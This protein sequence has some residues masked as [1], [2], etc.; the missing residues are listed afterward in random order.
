[1]PPSHNRIEISGLLQQRFIHHGQTTIEGNIAMSLYVGLDIG[2]TKFLVAS[3]DRD[4]TILKRAQEST[5]SDLQEGIDLL[6]EMIVSVTDGEKPAAIGAAIGGPL[7]WKRGVVSPLHQPQWR[8]V[9]LKAMMADRWGCPFFVDVD[10]N[11]A[12]L[13]EYY[14]G[15]EKAPRLLYLT[16]STGMGGSLLVDGE[17][18]RGAGGGH[19]EVAH[20]SINYHCRRP[21]EIECECGIPDCLEA[22]VSGNG[23]RRVYRRPAEC[24]TEREWDEVAYN[25]GQGLRNLAAIYL[26][27]VIVLGGGVALGRGD[28]LVDAASKVMSAHLRIVPVPE[29]RLSWLGYETALLG[30]IAAAIHGIR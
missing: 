27:D 8:E 25:L 24:L 5:P 16:V 9:P 18:Y 30:A 1:L 26:P 20:Q 28:M 13:G 7:D 15:D 17:I 3:A 4:G 14:F 6:N 12:A 19:P 29:V 10:T 23:I 22:L 2:G 21:K 11:V